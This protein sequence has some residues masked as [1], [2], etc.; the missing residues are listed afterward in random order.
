MNVGILALQGDYT[1]HAGA[2][3]RAGA[4]PVLVRGPAAL[5]RLDALVLPGGESTAMLHGIAREGLEE[6]LQRFFASGRPVLGT[7]AGAILLARTVTNPVQRS[8]GALDIDVERNAYGTQLDS[9]AT[10][11]D[12]A[13][14]LPRLSGLPAIF[15]RAPRI[16]RIG[17]GVDVLARVGGEPV[18]VH[19]ATVWAATFHPELSDDERMLREWLHQSRDTDALSDE[20][21][22]MIGESAAGAKTGERP[23]FLYL[24]YTAPHWPLHA[25]EEDIARYETTYRD[26]W[27]ATRQRRYERLLEQGLLTKETAALSPAA[28]GRP[29]SEGPHAEWEARAMAV[30]AAMV[31]RMDAGIGRVLEKLVAEDLAANTLVLFLSD[32]GASPERIARPGF[33]RPSHTR[34]GRE[35]VYPQ[36]DNPGPPPGPE[37]TFAGIGRRWA[38]VANT[39]F[40]MAKATAYEGGICTPCI[41]R[42]PATIHPGVTHEVGHVI[43]HGLKVDSVD[44]RGD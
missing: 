6:P 28:P 13:G 15:I 7:C 22:R 38:N 37:T 32:N 43:D 11:T 10:V 5:A 33:D 17:P 18:L 24:A 41:A 40:R 27:N 42:W 25:L 44:V 8:F 30:H 35:I 19:S 9:F 20:A 14:S 29:W 2:L 36:P 23:F 12:S 31:T 1:A 3:A 21:V 26:G 39:P 34:D 4:T 16:V